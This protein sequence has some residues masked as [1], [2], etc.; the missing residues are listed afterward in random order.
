MNENFP[1]VAILKKNTPQ[2]EHTLSALIAQMLADK[3]IESGTVPGLAWQ[4]SHFLGTLFGH[5]IMRSPYSLVQGQL[6]KRCLTTFSCLPSPQYQGTRRENVQ[7]DSSIGASQE[8]GLRGST[9]R[10]VAGV[11]ENAA[12]KIPAWLGMIRIAVIGAG[13]AGLLAARALLDVGFKNIIIFDQTGRIG[14]IWS[15]DFLTRAS[16]ANPF[17]LHFEKCHL[18]AAPGSGGAVMEWLHTIADSGVQPFPKVVKARV[19]AVR[20]DDLS[21]TLL[22]EDEWGV[23]HEITVPVVINAVGV[24]DPLLPSRPGVMT[25]DVSP[26]D[27]GHRWQ[28]VW[29]PQQACDYHHRTCIFIS[30]SNST[31]EIVKQIQWYQREGLDKDYKINTHYTK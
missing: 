21:H 13:A 31:L 12:L 29:T 19:L 7:V 9:W 30:L 18:E 25:T 5:L 26:F 28:E 20:P 14:G 16:R 8:C 6:I 11:Y 10:G 23:Q 2:T 15:Q 1:A 17:P 22:F 3:G 4:S 24:G 27:A